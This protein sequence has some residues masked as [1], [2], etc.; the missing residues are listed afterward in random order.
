MLIL[1]VPR[2]P[3][4]TPN[5][6]GLLAIYAHEPNSP[7][8]RPTALI[9]TVTAAQLPTLVNVGG[10]R[11]RRNL[12]W[13][14]QRGAHDGRRRHVEPAARRCGYRRAAAAAARLLH[15]RPVRVCGGR[16]GHAGVHVHRRRHVGDAL[17]VRASTSRQAHQH[18]HHVTLGLG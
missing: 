10:N 16:A 12:T 15:R 5:A 6:P 7:K 1:R 11:E 17:R 8:P 14:R 9:H 18:H 2:T 4:W 13:R 3:Q